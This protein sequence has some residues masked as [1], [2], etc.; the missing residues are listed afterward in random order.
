MQQLQQPPV[1]TFNLKER[2][3]EHTGIKRNFNI[4]RTIALINSPKCQERVRNRGMLGFLGHWPRIAFGM[5]PSEG[6]ISQGKTQSIE[7]AVVTVLLRGHPDGTIE[8]KTEFLLESDTGKIAARAFAGKIGGFSSVI[9]HSVPEFY[10]FDWVNDPNFSTNRGYE[11]TMDSAASGMTLS[12]I[13]AAS[14]AE[15]MQ[16]MQRLLDVAEGNAG[17]ALDTANRLFAENEDLLGMIASGHKAGHDLYVPAGSKDLAA[18]LLA[19]SQQFLDSTHAR[20]LE[21]LIDKP[22]DKPEPVDRDYEQLAGRFFNHV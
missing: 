22:K 16:I 17:F 6:G 15:R 9:D 2:G 13:V 3:R 21:G 12:D 10:G 5:E 19:E 1:I 14:Y 7:P 11:L 20:S 8:H 18:K 4:P